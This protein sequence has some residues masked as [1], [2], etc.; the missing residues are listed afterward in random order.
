MKVKKVESTI[1]PENFKI[2]DQKGNLTE[3]AFFDE[4][5]EIT[6]PLEDGTEQTMYS[7]Y[8]YK[9]KVVSRNDLEAY[10]SENLDTWLQ[11]A[12]NNFIEEKSQ[13]IRAIRNKLLAESDSHV[14]LDRL[15]ISIPSN[16]TATTLLTVIKNLFSSLGTILNG[17]WSKYRQA[18]RDITKQEGFP[19]DVE[20]PTSPED[21]TTEEDN[22]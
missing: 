8:V 18:L 19:F 16:I 14:L 21:N 11:L 20:F 15:G 6:R 2:G 17:D 22:I 4:I 10:I 3:V 7:Y 1:R 5:E 9:V 12:K 13:E